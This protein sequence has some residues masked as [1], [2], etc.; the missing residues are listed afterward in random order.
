MPSPSPIPIPLHQRWHDVRL[1]Y[2]PALIF[3]AIV[4]VL[5]LLW[6]DYS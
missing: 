1:R 6:K 2:I 5:A 3:I 4:F